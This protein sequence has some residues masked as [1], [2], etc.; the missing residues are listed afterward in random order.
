[1]KP[2]GAQHCPS[3]IFFSE[4][5]VKWSSQSHNFNGDLTVDVDDDVENNKIS[6]FSLSFV[7]LSMKTYMDKIHEGIKPGALRG[8]SQHLAEVP[9]PDLTSLR[10]T[11]QMEE[12]KRLSSILK[13]SLTEK[14]TQTRKH[15]RVRVWREYCSAFVLF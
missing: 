7:F 13:C 15:R 8:R 2:P 9:A 11:K 10:A 1:M 12:S 5:R 4:P 6:R 3:R 14:K